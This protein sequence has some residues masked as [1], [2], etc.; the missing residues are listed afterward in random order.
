MNH[1]ILFEA[2]ALSKSITDSHVVP[3]LIGFQSSQLQGPLSQFQAVQA[4]RQGTSKLIQLINSALGNTVASD[5]LK[6]SFD[7]FW[8][9]L[10]SELA[11]ITSEA[12]AI[13]LPPARSTSDMFA[14][15]LDL[16]RSQR[17]EI[18]GNADQ[19]K[20]PLATSVRAVRMRRGLSQT[21]LAERTGIPEEV[22]AQ[23][24]SMP[25][26]PFAPTEAQIS[27]IAR[28]LDA[29]FVEVRKPDFGTA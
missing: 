10:E 25:L 3:Y 12:T 23:I 20:R 19:V 27:L 21:E 9:Q 28:A 6:D 24:E 5:V 17:F 4:D 18:I 7:L 29:G 16:L 1:G 22:I 13:T 26:P 15:I 2:G 14:E 11:R 8:P